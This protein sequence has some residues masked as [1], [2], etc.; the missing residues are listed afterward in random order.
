MADSAYE[1][2]RTMA[3]IFADVVGDDPSDPL[4]LP[5]LSEEDIS[6]GSVL[7]FTEEQC[8]II[9]SDT[10]TRRE[11]RREWV[12]YADAAE[13]WNKR[14]ETKKLT[15]LPRGISEQMEVEAYS[16][17]PRWHAVLRGISYF[18]PIWDSAWPNIVATLPRS[19]QALLSED[20]REGFIAVTDGWEGEIF[21]PGEVRAQAGE[22]VPKGVFY[23][24]N[25][26]EVVS[27][28][29]DDD[30]DKV[31][32]AFDVR[33]GVKLDGDT[34]YV[35]TFCEKTSGTVLVKLWWPDGS[36]GIVP[37]K[38][39]QVGL[40]FRAELGA[41]DRTEGPVNITIRKVKS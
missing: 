24:Y 28:W 18:D 23:F 11:L 5:L 9:L 14:N 31:V 30:W 29:R 17:G 38:C 20:E 10:L 33:A 27:L 25:E 16:G 26:A 32:M 19:A 37:I 34:L 4:R 8:W 41:S 1:L 35:G 36:T 6:E 2:W 13:F 15:D 12:K 39:E 40:P 22:L 21:G 3:D 7:G